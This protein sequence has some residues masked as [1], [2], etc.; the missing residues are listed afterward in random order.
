MSNFSFNKFIFIKQKFT[1]FIFRMVQSWYYHGIM[2]FTINSFFINGIFIGID[3]ITWVIQ[4]IYSFWNGIFLFAYAA[5]LGLE[6]FAT[7]K[8]NFYAMITACIFMCIRF[9]VC[10]NNVESYVCINLGFWTLLRIILQGRIIYMIHEKNR[11]EKEY[12]EIPP[13]YDRFVAS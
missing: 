4:L 12:Y 7:I 9:F 2:D 11:L 6:I 1:F 8:K 13:T 3:I 10:F 5:F